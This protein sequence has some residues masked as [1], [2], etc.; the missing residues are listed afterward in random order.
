MG[1]TGLGA[2]GPSASQ[3]P[4]PKSPSPRVPTDWKTTMMEEGQA[5]LS[6]SL[7]MQLLTQREERLLTWGGKQAKSWT[8]PPS[9]KKQRPWVQATPPMTDA[10]CPPHMS[11]AWDAPEA[12]GTS[13]TDRVKAQDSGCDHCLHLPTPTMVPPSTTHPACGLSASLKPC[14]CV[15]VALSSGEAPEAS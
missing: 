7:V 5:L 3:C 2:A 10:L 6:G 12:H 9:P 8:H 14:D 15:Y 4:S 1:R 11:L 13:C